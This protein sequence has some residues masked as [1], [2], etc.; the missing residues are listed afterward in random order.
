MGIAAVLRRLAPNADTATQGGASMP[1]DRYAYKAFISYSHSADGKLAPAVQRGLHRFAKPWYRLRAMR[2]FRDE[3]TLATSPEL[4]PSIELALSQSEYFLYLASPEAARSF[5]VRKEFEYWVSHR[6]KDRMLIILT[7][8]ELIWD[9]DAQDFDWAATTAVP[10]D[11][12]HGFRD[13]PLYLDLR[14]ARTEDHL[15]LSNLR[16]R[17]AIADVAST[18][19]GQPKDVLVGEDVRQHRRTRKIAWSAAATLVALTIVSVVA[20]VVAVQN[21]REAER[22]GAI[23]LSRQ[24]ATQAVALAGSD[25]G[26]LALLLS[27]EALDVHPT[28]DASNGLLAALTRDPYRLFHLHGHMGEVQGLAFSPDSDELLSL[29]CEGIDS[30]GLCKHFGVR[31]WS[32]TSGDPRGQ[33]ILPGANRWTLLARP[34]SGGSLVAHDGRAKTWDPLTGHPLGGARSPLLSSPRGDVHVGREGRDLVLRETRTRRRLVA[35]FARGNEKIKSV[36]FHPSAPLVA[37]GGS[38]GEVRLWDTDALRN[39]SQQPRRIIDAHGKAVI[40]LDFSPD[41]RY[42]VTASWDDSALVWDL[43][44]ETPARRLVEGANVSSVT[45]SPDGR[46][47]VVAISIGERGGELRLWDTA[48]WRRVGTLAGKQPVAF[49]SN[50]HLLA[51]AGADGAI[52]VRDLDRDRPLGQALEDPGDPMSVAFLDGGRRLVAGG[53]DQS[54][55]IWDVES[56]RLEQAPIATDQGWIHALAVHPDGMRLASGGT[57]GRILLWDIEDLATGPTMTIAGHDDAPVAALDFSADGA[58]LVSGG[59]DDTLRFWHP[60]TGDPLARA[61]IDTGQDVYVARFDG[62]G[63]RVASATEDGSVL[64][65]ELSDD[66]A[67]GSVVGTHLLQSDGMTGLAFGPGDRFLVSS[68]LEQTQL[69]GLAAGEPRVRTPIEGSFAALGPRGEWLALATDS[70][71]IRLVDVHTWRAFDA[72]LGHQRDLVF[73]LAFSP[74]AERLASAAEGDVVVWDVSLESWRE[75][76]CA[77]ARRNLTPEE[78]DRYLGD[79]PYVTT[80]PGAVDPPRIPLDAERALGLAVR[81]A[82]L[83]ETAE[84]RRLFA[85]AARLAADGEAAELANRIC[86][87]GAPRDAFSEVMIAC[88][89]AVEL[90]PDNAG[91]RDSRGVARALAGNITGAI[92]DLRAYVTKVEDRGKLAARRDRR[93]IWIDALEAGRDPFDSME[94]HRVRSEGA[95]R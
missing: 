12:D 78:W 89:R 87:F 7:D 83:G 36:A 76:A 6:S 60:T 48:R 82:K 56:G 8:G 67:T 41:G 59:F 73:A 1:E 71:E 72:T 51:S 50:G 42:L 27:L 5:W 3:T 57:S 93:Q 2:A 28:V 30:L 44:A 47:L 61:P 52:I 20:A 16:F 21:Q 88:E 43:E 24:L 18:L 35:P 34:A 38:M 53:R 32:A 86:W 4:W 11:I 31:R 29:G 95:F 68:S 65:W 10:R 55:R 64:L 81:A 40:D 58:Q 45:F 84:A 25:R 39:G 22:R 79:R 70:G 14:W 46:R 80:C 66:G 69:W 74:D 85:E 54:L 49:H 33:A 15:S 92:E 94:L 77:M 62:T 17:S 91:Y 63:S 19:L 23:A 13:E 37:L 26:D 75:R 9:R 90:D